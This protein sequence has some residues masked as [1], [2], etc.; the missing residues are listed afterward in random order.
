MMMV[1]RWMGAHRTYDKIL[2]AVE[3]PA[4]A[5]TRL[6]DLELDLPSKLH[7]LLLLVSFIMVMCLRDG[8]TLFRQWGPHLQLS[9]HSYIGWRESR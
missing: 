1:S 9:L 8:L 5:A 3:T 6:E 7:V 2:F 4:S